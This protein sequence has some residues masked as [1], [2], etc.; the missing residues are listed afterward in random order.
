MVR[1]KPI[2]QSQATKTSGETQSNANL[3]RTAQKS[4]LLTLFMK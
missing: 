1:W 4:L 3:Q 2:G